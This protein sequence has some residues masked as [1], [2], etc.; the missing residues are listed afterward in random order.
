MAERC[1]FPVPFCD[2]FDFPSEGSVS[3]QDSAL[4]LKLRNFDELKAALK[5]FSEL[6]EV[7]NIV[8]PASE[9]EAMR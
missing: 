7:E 4:I 6:V 3:W 9:V 5:K 2:V 1:D 8:S